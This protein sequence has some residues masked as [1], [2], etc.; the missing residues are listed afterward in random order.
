MEKV[1][2]R[3]SDEKW[4]TSMERLTEIEEELKHMDADT[5]EYKCRKILAGLGFSDEAMLR[6]VKTFSGGWRMRVSIAKALFVQPKLLMLDEPTNHL[7]LDAVI[8][9]DASFSPQGCTAP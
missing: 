6:P 1:E 3:W 5:A 2:G 7:D 4:M 9:L 8:W